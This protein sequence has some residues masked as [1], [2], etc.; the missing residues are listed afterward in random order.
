[1]AFPQHLLAYLLTFLGFFIF[2]EIVLIARQAVASTYVHQV[3]TTAQA[4]LIQ[5]DYLPKGW[6]E[7]GEIPAGPLESLKI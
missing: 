5:N 3:L 4:S 6:D 2:Q 7:I 1:M